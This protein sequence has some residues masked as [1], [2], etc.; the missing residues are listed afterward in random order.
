MSSLVTTLAFP[1]STISIEGTPLF[2]YENAF[3]AKEAPCLARCV[4]DAIHHRMFAVAVR[5]DFGFAHGS[6]A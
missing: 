1:R 5:T 4:L 3:L 6:T 2:H